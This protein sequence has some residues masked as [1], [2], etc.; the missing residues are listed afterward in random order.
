MGL[1]RRNK[2][3][4]RG[5][6]PGPVYREDIVRTTLGSMISDL[7]HGKTA[8]QDKP[9]NTFL[10]DLIQEAMPKEKSDNSGRKTGSQIDREKTNP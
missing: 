8:S 3:G 2:H 5:C 1:C 6:V 10:N 4:E 7:L 9:L